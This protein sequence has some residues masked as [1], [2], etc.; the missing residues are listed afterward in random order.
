MVTI[1]GGFLVAYL[2]MILGIIGTIV[3]LLPGAPLIWLGAL[4]WAWT[5]NFQRVGWPM[6]VLLGLLA[7]VALVSNWFMTTLTS[8]KAGANWKSVLGAM[9]GGIAGGFLLSAV[10]VVGTLFGALIG[11]VAGML[12]LEYWQKRDAKLAWRSAIAYILGHLASSIV[13]FVICLVMLALFA[14]QAFF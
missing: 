13:E 9:A 11:A 3:P 1:E 6:L 4:M 10:P 8:R 7:V 2:L 12:V 14:W 5:D